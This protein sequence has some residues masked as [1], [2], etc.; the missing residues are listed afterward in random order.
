MFQV[1][2]HSLVGT[3]HHHAV[4]ILKSSGIDIV[5]VVS[6][7][8]PSRPLPVRSDQS[9]SAGTHDRLTQPSAA[10]TC[11]RFI[12]FT[13]LS[14]AGSPDRFTQPSAAGTHDKLTQPSAAGTHDR[15]LSVT[16]PSEAG[17]HERLTQ[18]LAA[19]TRD[20]LISVTQ[21]S[22][23]GAHDRLIQ[24]SAAGTHDRLIQ[25][26]AAGTHDRLTQPSAAGTHDRFTQPS[27][28]G[29]HDRL[30]SNTWPLVSDS[31]LHTSTQR[32][33]S[34]ENLSNLLEERT[35][36]TGS[37]AV[38]FVKLDNRQSDE[39]SCESKEYL[40]VAGGQTGSSSLSHCSLSVDSP[41]QSHSRGSLRPMLGFTRSSA[42]STGQLR[43]GD[44]YHDTESWQSHV[45][46]HDSKLQ[47]HVMYICYV[48]SFQKHSAVRTFTLNS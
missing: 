5:T 45:A 19:G 40:T 1:N 37:T 32:L 31:L 24:Q 8:Q 46:A 38:A 6:R 44:G 33:Q 48:T 21:P 18:P 12:S 35:I 26:S 14:T 30:I 22:A 28:A 15:L 36:H 10:G 34:A 39:K 41:L 7:P 3:S 23:A 11:D 9:S 42:S 27:A 29:T 13:Q 4:Q 17:T 43:A 25:P 16:Q 2:G 20:R 47:H